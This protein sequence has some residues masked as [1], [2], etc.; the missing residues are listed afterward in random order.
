MYKGLPALVVPLLPP[1]PCTTG[2][3]RHPRSL[4]RSPRTES[5][6][7]S[8][9]PRVWRV[10]MSPLGWSLFRNRKHAWIVV[11]KLD[12]VH[13]VFWKFC[14]PSLL[15]W[16]KRCTDIQIHIKIFLSLPTCLSFMT[17]CAPNERCVYACMSFEE[18]RPH[19][20]LRCSMTIAPSR[21][22][23]NFD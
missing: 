14:S 16:S 11:P 13:Q 1:S 20:M 17:L 15:I 19:L 10:R 8:I 18:G 22:I 7:L 9:A 5:V 12:L 4:A 6:V 3:T 21:V 2:E 23:P